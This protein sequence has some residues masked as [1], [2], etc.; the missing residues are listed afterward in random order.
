MRASCNGLRTAAL[1]FLNGAAVL[2]PAAKSEA[3]DLVALLFQ[4]MGR[5]A[6]VDASTH[7]DTDALL[8]RALIEVRRAYY[9]EVSLKSTATSFHFSSH[10][11]LCLKSNVT[12]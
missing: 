6:G 3:D 2:R 7:T 1:V 10:S 4:Q 11:V 12:R 8:L 5:D 9:V